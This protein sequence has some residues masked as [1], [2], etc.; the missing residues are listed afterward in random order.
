METEYGQELVR[1]LK[2]VCSVTK[3][4][5][6][7]KQKEQK[8]Y[9]DQRSKEIELQVGDLVMLKTEPWFKL[10]HSFKG[11]FVVKS[12]TSTNAMIQ[13]KDDDTTELLNVSRQWLSCCDLAISAATPWVGHCAKL[14]RRH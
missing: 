12:L 6:G 13:L 10:D 9:Y 2:Q 8:K 4:N 3:Q 7:K 1:E 14:R 5:I 11:P